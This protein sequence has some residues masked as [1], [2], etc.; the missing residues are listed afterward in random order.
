V[1]AFYRI[2]VT[3][4]LHRELA[5][6]HIFSMTKRWDNMSMWAKYADNHAGYCLEFS[7]AGLFAAACEVEYGD[8]AAIDV[9]ETGMDMNSFFAS[10]A[11]GATKKRYGS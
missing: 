6:L 2:R 4:L 7:N 5:D 11:I 3:A 1:P 10:D 8:V 9:T